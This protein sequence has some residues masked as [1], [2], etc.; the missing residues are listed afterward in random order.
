MSL[1]KYP[2]AKRD[3]I[4]TTIDRKWLAEIVAETK[5]VEYRKVNEYWTKTLARVRPPFEL[6]LINGMHHPIPEVTV[7]VNKITID[8]VDRRYELHIEK[9]LEVKHWD[10]RRRVPKP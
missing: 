1:K 9:I 8:K 10:K 7:L 6:R 2:T 4:T 5:D 3:R